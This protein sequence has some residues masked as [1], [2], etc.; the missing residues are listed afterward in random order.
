MDKKIFKRLGLLLTIV[1]LA[2]VGVFVYAANT[3]TFTQSINAG[4]LSVDI[5]D[6]SYNPVT[7]PTMDMDAVDFSF[8]CQTA[9]G[10]FSSSTE[11]IYVKNPD[12]A[13]SGWSITLAASSP[14]SIWD[15]AET[16]F[17]FNDPDG[18]DSEGAGCVDSDG[19]ASTG[20][21]SDGDSF[22]GQ[23]T[24]DPSSATLATGGCSSCTTD[25]ITKGSSASFDEGNT[26]SITILSGATE[27][28]DIGDWTLQGVDINQTIPAEQPAADD[29]S[30]DMVLT[31]TAN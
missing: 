25:N 1:V 19:D 23:M 22:A 29:Y 12:A 21:N 11:Q 9:S 4:S 17:D 15:S 24:V 20:D 2:G 13:D 10:T 7:S 16:D 3:S 26:D 6:G 27:S 5:V 31:V 8:S 18:A 14:T 30:I 28:D